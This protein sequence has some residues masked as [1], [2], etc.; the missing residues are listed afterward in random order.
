MAFDYGED[1]RKT[2]PRPGMFQ[3]VRTGAPDTGVGCGKAIRTGFSHAGEASAGA[4]NGGIYTRTLFGQNIRENP[5]PV[6]TAKDAF[7]TFQDPRTGRRIGLSRELLAYGLLTLGAP[8]S[9]KTNL[10]YMILKWLLATQQEN[11]IL[12]IFDTKGDYLQEF[13]DRIPPEER[14]VIGVGEMYREISAYH[15]IFAEIMP[16]ANN[17][18]LVYTPDSDA[19]AMEISAQIFQG[20]ES[21]TQPVFPAM[22]QQIFSAVLIYFMRTYWRTDQSRLN[23][24]ELIAFLSE[25]TNEEL[26]AI[27]SLDYMK[28]ERRCVDYIANKSNQ[29]QGVNSYLGTVVKQIFTGPF[30]QSCPGREFSMQEI[31]TSPRRKVLFIEYDLKRGQTLSP[32]YGMLIDRALANALGGRMAARNRVYI[33]LDEMLL[34]PKLSHLQN[35]LNFGRSQ[36][37]RLLCGL[38]NTPGVANLYGGEDG[39]KAILASFQNIISFSIS[40]HET[41]RFLIDR[42]GAN[43]QNISFSALQENLNIQREGHTVE[44]W[45]LLE[46]RPGGGDALVSLKGE[47]PFFFTMPKY[48]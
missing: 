26:K 19:D 28:S 36:G 32:M 13:G 41:R 8:G 40:D 43:Y 37:V 14:V 1:D 5:V 21:E 33:V 10:L 29:T 24:Q 11:E 20:M 23:N 38:Q 2:M 7:V 18:T 46:M 45:D 17:G 48:K 15:N 3:A 12:V 44:E 16:R 4:P 27:F 31:V 47:R 34:L 42:M 30:A 25:K 9:G 39:A 35:A 6:H 22:A